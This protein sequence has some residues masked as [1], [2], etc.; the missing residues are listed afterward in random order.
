MQSKQEKLVIDHRNKESIIS[1]SLF[2]LIFHG[3]P[4]ES[5]AA[6]RLFVF[7]A[8]LNAMIENANEIIAINPDLLRCSMI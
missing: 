7:A 1:P 8:Q 6:N 2:G 4:D 3:V 5:W